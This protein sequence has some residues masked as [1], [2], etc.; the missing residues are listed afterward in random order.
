[1]PVEASIS[2]GKTAAGG[3]IL[4]S[5]GTAIDPSKVL[6]G[7]ADEHA[8]TLRALRKANEAVFVAPSG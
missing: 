2:K 3:L 7:A 8:C 4:R 6:T 5:S 1:M